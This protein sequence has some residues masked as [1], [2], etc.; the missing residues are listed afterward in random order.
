MSVLM[1]AILR[2][3]HIAFG[4]FWLG[5]VISV[6]LFLLPKVDAARLIS[7]DIAARDLALRRLL[8]VVA[9]AGL[10]AVGAGHILYFGLWRGSAFS[11]PGFWYAAGGQPANIAA[12]VTAFVAWP[13]AVRLCALSRSLVGQGPSATEEQ[14]AMRG[15]L[16]RRIAWTSRLS[17]VLLVVTVTLMAIGR[18]V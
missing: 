5:G 12:L 15:R 4:A 16:I 3:V 6:G 14:N 8:T 13:A 18:Y 7:D 9:A 10:V 11:G 1:I 17:G 2:S